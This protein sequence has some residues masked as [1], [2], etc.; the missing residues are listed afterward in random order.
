MTL[1]N[2]L[3]TVAAAI[4]CIKVQLRVLM[5]FQFVIETYFLHQSLT[6]LQ[7]LITAH[8][9]LTLSFSH[10]SNHQSP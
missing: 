2:F 10:S 9:P 6:Q 8:N 5:C 1:N 4:V 7:Q 3:C